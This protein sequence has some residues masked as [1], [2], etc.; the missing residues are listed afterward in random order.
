MSDEG[1]AVM[2]HSYSRHSPIT[3]YAFL[4]A[5]STGPVCGFTPRHR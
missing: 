3:H 5:S 1:E 4:T 2:L